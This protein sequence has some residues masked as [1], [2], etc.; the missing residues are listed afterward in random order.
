MDSEPRDAELIA[1]F[2]LVADPD[3]DDELGGDIGHLA[4]AD[5]RGCRVLI[6]RSMLLGQDLG[7]IP[8][9]L[10]GLT[11]S[12]QATQNFR[13]SWA[14]VWIELFS[15]ADIL[16]VDVEPSTKFEAEAVEV[17]V[18][19]DGNLRVEP[20]TGL[21]ASKNASTRATY[22]LH[23]CCVHGTGNGTRKGRWEL[24]E[25]PHTRGG[26]S[27]SLPLLMTLNRS[28]TIRGH[29]S[30]NAKLIRPGPHG[31]LDSVRY[32][33]LGPEQHVAPLTMCIP[34]PVRF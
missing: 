25:N 1:N 3:Q 16:F 33:I 21:I 30:V 12:F 23:H 26:I 28:G 6:S 2:D 32:M 29:V 14:Q 10:V 4:D 22:N 7:G 15:P 13:F 19:T 17:S 18:T 5:L 9:G 31:R 8:G 24:Y 34:P 27:H 20:A 11:C